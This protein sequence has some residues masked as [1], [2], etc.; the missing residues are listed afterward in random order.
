MLKQGKLYMEDPPKDNGIVTIGKATYESL[1]TRASL[2]ENWLRTMLVEVYKAYYDMSPDY[3][4]ELFTIKNTT[5][6]QEYY[7]WSR[8]KT[9]TRLKA[10]KD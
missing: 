10:Q 3:I 9:T 2:E 5:Y 4:N 1:L 7:L 8:K 6:H